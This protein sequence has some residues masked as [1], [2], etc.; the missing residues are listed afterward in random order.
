MQQKKPTI[1]FLN[2]TQQ[3]LTE[4][5]SQEQQQCRAPNLEGGAAMILQS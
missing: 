2:G 4:K 3:L 1:Y 5:Q